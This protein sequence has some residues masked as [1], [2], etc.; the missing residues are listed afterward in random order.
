M[1]DLAP[2]R[3]CAWSEQ[4][5]AKG[6]DTSNKE[7]FEDWRNRN[8][9]RLFGL[10]DLLCEQWIYRYWCRAQFSF[11]ALDTLTCEETRMSTTE[12]LDQIHREYGVTP[13]PARDIHVFENRIHESGLHPTARAFANL[14]TWDYPI[15]VL[16]TP[17]GIK[18][19]R[20]ENDQIK[21]VL[22]EGHQRHR[23]LMALSHAQR[24]PEGP[25]SVYIL[26]SPIV[27]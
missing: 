10:P 20:M 8:S 12:I 14:N 2:Q 13:D 18:N 7:S 6:H 15:V 21:L 11:L 3:Q 27:K 5:R 22:V 4:L 16:R 26:E 9:E 1:F 24:A 23:Y 19:R 25:H 17:H